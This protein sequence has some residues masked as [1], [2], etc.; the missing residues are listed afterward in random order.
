MFTLAL[1]ITAG[2][3]PLASDTATATARRTDLVLPARACRLVPVPNPTNKNMPVPPVVRCADDNGH[4][5]MIAAGCH[6]ERIAHPGSKGMPAA[7][8]MRCSAAAQERLAKARQ[9]RA[10]QYASEPA[11]AGK[12]GVD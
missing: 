8:T 11:T 3:A 7:P 9:A 2:A 1:L 6:I 5:E 10:T 12:V 4:R